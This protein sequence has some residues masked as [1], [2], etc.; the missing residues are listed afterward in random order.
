MQKFKNGVIASG[1]ENDSVVE[2]ALVDGQIVIKLIAVP[3]WT[4]DPLL[5]GVNNDNLQHETDTGHAVGNE[6]W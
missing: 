6:V 3:T 4:L 1:L 5:S 2:V